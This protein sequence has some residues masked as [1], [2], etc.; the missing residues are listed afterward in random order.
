MGEDYPN[1]FPQNE[2]GHFFRKLMSMVDSMS[3][4]DLERFNRFLMKELK[5]GLANGSFDGA[6]EFNF[7]DNETVKISFMDMDNVDREELGSVL[8]MI[9]PKEAESKMDL[10]EMEGLLEYYVENEMYEEAATL[11]DKINSLKN[12]K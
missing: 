7:G 6:K 5:N 4:Q 8:D 12:D 11:R 1:G 9:E 10:E 2:D 3:P